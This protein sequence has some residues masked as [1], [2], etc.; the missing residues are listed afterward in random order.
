MSGGAR[1]AGSAFNEYS[2]THLGESAQ[3]VGRGG[4]GVCKPDLL[5]L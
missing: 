3:Q 1:E 2:V 5:L 4:R